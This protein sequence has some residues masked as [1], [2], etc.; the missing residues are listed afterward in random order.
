MSTF[1]FK[2]N[3]L[4]CVCVLEMF[5]DLLDHSHVLV[6][7]KCEVVGTH[8]QTREHG[9]VLDVSNFIVNHLLEVRNFII[10]FNILD[11][12]LFDSVKMVSFP[13]ETLL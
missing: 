5:L 6:E 8:S 3:E 1:P 7:S 11:G 2:V 4:L 13:T 12:L 9:V 10:N